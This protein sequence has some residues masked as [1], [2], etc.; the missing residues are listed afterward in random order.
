ML[1]RARNSFPVLPAAVRQSRTDSGWSMVALAILLAVVAGVVI[2]LVALLGGGRGSVASRSA[3]AFDEAQRK[4]IPVGEAAHGGHGAPSPGGMEM[5]AQGKTGMAGHAGMEMPAQGKTGMAGH[6][7]MEMPGQGKT[8]MAGHAMP[9][10]A[11]PEPLAKAAVA[12]PGQPAATLEPDPLDAPAAT[13]E[14]DAKRS[15]ELAASMGSGGMTHDMGSY[16]QLDAGRESVQKAQ[17]AMPD[18]QGMGH[19][20]MPPSTP[21]PA[22]MKPRPVVTPAPTPRGHVHPSGGGQR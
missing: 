10:G 9:G 17:P 8:G 20:S 22:T 5:P 2:A 18:H 3:A 19:G 1:F 14:M 4:G 13:S 21:T 15:T 7:G 16:R 12:G 6:A 11:P